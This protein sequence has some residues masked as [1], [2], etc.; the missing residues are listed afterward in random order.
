MSKSCQIVRKKA[1]II[2]KIVL[3]EKLPQKW[4]RLSAEEA[5]L[6]LK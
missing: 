3:K 5:F 2:K 1:R 6:V 4:Y